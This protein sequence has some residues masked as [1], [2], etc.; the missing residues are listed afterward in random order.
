MIGKHCKHSDWVVCDQCEEDEPAT[1]IEAVAQAICNAM[2]AKDGEGWS[3]A[4]DDQKAEFR[5]GAVAAISAFAHAD[6]W[7][8]YLPFRAL[9]E[10][11]DSYPS[12]YVEAALPLADVRQLLFTFRALAAG[13]RS[14]E[15]TSAQ[16]EG[17]QSGGNAVTP[18]HS[19]PM[20]GEG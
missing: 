13:T 10:R 7:D 12:D 15:T 1:A 16:S 6:P 8:A 3:V 20:T 19:H 4:G 14:A 5:E 9:Q 2:W 18:E 11:V 17:C